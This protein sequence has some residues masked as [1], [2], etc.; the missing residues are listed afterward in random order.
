MK[1]KNKEEEVKRETESKCTDRV[2]TASSSSLPF[3]FF[4]PNTDNF[5]KDEDLD[6]SDPRHTDVQM[7]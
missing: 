6:T 1:K 5:S 3:L 7:Q 2:I 4:S